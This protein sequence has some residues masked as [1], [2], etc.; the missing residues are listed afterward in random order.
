MAL[1][2]QSIEKRDFPV[3]RRGYDPDAVDVHLSALADEV[4]ELRASA[5][6]RSDTL[7]SSASEQVGAIVQA[8]EVSAAE[9]LRAAESDARE[10]RAEA[11]TDA[12]AMRE[13]ATVQS[14]EFVTSVSGSTESMLDRLASMQTELDS[15]VGSLRGGAGRL[16]ADLGA[17]HGDLGDARAGLSPHA[18]E[19][20]SAEEPVFDPEATERAETPAADPYGE[21]LSDPAVSEP[22]TDLDAQ[23]ADAPLADVEGAQLIALNMALNGTPREETARYLVENFAIVDSGGLLDEVYASVGG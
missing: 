2:R 13:T 11:E 21:L 23:A 22:G 12:R 19:P 6:R 14:R 3:G 8:A 7:A 10:I 9:I 20:E 1:D 16:S 18:F 5:R 4:E 15:L 17:L